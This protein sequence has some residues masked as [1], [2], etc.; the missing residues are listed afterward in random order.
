MKAICVVK[1][2]QKY[3]LSQIMQAM[4]GRNIYVTVKLIRGGYNGFK[5][6]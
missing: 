1:I 5:S 6:I 4:L 3:R 2:N